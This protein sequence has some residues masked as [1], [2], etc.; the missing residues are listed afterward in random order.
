M[1]SE[2]SKKLTRALILNALI[3]PGSGHIMIGAT[4]Q[5]VTIAS[6]TIVFLLAPIIRFITAFQSAIRSQPPPGVSGPL[7]IL[8]A[9]GQAWKA[10]G[11]F[12][13]ICLFAVILVWAYGIGDIAVRI[14]R[15]KIKDDDQGEMS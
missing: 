1:E 8:A 14:R 13:L 5:G 6:A 7:G 10:H 9:A 3:L 12:I 15:G 4:L 11:A 2:S